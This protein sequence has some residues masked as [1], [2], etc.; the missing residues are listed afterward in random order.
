MHAGQFHTLEQVVEHY[1]QAPPAAVGRT[2][3]EQLGLTRAER[4][5]IRAFLSALEGPV[6][7]PPGFLDRPR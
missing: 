2:E 3:L 1:D 5:A 7:A 4:A 6:L